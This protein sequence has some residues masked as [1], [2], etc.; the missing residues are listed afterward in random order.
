MNV[1]VRKVNIKMNKV[2]LYVKIVP[3][4]GSLIVTDYLNVVNVRQGNT[5]I[6]LRPRFV[7]HA[8]RGSMLMHLKV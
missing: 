3:K 7:Q 1:G 6:Y 2:N 4:E 8:Y 5:R